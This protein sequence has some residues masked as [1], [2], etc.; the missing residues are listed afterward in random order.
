MMQ[1]QYSMLQAG[2][3]SSA[4]AGG[5]IANPLQGDLLL[6]LPPFLKPAD[7]RLGSRAFSRSNITQSA[8]QFNHNAAAC[9]VC[10]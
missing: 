5:F 8:T 3:F 7:G 10:L 6:H 4:S 2:S 1:S 9:G